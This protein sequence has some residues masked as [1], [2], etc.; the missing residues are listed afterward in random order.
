MSVG[1]YLCTV[2]P[3]EVLSKINSHGNLTAPSDRWI[4][5]TFQVNVRT[6]QQVQ[7]HMNDVEILGSRPYYSI[8]GHWNRE[9]EYG[10]RQRV[11]GLFNSHSIGRNTTD[12]C[13]TKSTLT[14]HCFLTHK[15]CSTTR[16]TAVILGKKMR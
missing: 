1:S 13:Y 9:D 6:F 8:N 3:T 4:Y 14:Q 10:F 7:K 16:N 11:R 2:I 15:N 5:I 12:T